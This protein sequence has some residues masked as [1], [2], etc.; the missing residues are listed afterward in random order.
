MRNLTLIILL[1]ALLGSCTKQEIELPALVSDNMVLQ[2]QSD[3]NLWGWFTPGA[4]I[5]I[6]ASWGESATAFTD[7]D[8]KWMTTIK[9]PEFGGPYTISFS[10]GSVTKEISNVLIGEVW[11]C[12]GQ[13]NMEMPLNGFPPNDVIQNAEVEKQNA[14][15]PELRMFT[16]AKVISSTPVKDCAGNWESASP[17]TVGNFS[18]S[19]YFFGRKIHQELGIPVGLIHS[20]WGGTPAESWTSAKNIVTVEGFENLK[21]QLDEMTKNYALLK[22]F[23]TDLY[24]IPVTSL[25][26]ER[27][28]ENLQLN[29]GMFADKNFDIDAMGEMEVPS[30]W[31]TS[32]L[33]GY[34]GI[35]WMF[36]DFEYNGSAKNLQLYLGPIDDMDAVYLNGVKVG[37]HEYSG[38][39]NMERIYDIPEDLI[40]QGENRIAVRVIDTGGGGGIFGP[41]KPA[42]LAGDEPLVGLSGKWK[43][44]PTATFFEGSI[45]VWGEGDKSFSAAP[46]MKLTMDQNSPTALYNAMINPLIPFTI[47]GAIWYQG[48]S[49]VGRGKQYET[50]F[51]TMIQNWREDWNQGNFPFYFV[52]IAPYNYGPNSDVAVAE[53][54]DAQFKTLALENTGMAVTMDIGNPRNIHPANKQD[55]GDR[56]ARWALNKDYGFSEVLC[57]GPLYKSAEFKGRNVIVSFDYAG[58]GLKLTDDASFV[59][60]AGSD[61]VFHKAKV[62]IEGEKL[63]ASSAKVNNPVEIRYAWCDDC[64]PNLFN[65]EGL[66]ASPFHAKK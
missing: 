23:I 52:Q 47:K 60:L 14:S 51:P 10:S 55:V 58:A 12:S 30:L 13:S 19:A 63:V 20:S 6:D 38:V 24:T 61:G 32:V 17:E 16:V 34:D 26:G 54:R 37:S 46:K 35:V 18:A 9:T 42:I 66:P 50:L 27:P 21:E 41:G 57:S 56:L 59:E 44:H 2:Q 48:E 22:E 4:N 31:E 36:K 65:K 49:N 53:L 11:L 29:D 62:K 64:E 28:Y 39:Y 25:I 45:V 1:I 7:E 40:N 8:G 43:Y 33:P 15:F 3:I 5:K